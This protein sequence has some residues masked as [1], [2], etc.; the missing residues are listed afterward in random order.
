MIYLVYTY[1]I[2]LQSSTLHNQPMPMFEWKSSSFEFSVHSNCYKTI[3]FSGV[4]YQTKFERNLL[5]MLEGGQGV[6]GGGVFF[7]Y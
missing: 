5:M 6:G 4:H 1:C 7:F 2:S 3:Q